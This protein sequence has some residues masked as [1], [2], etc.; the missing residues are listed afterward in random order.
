MHPLDCYQLT[1]EGR[2]LDFFSSDTL[3]RKTRHKLNNAPKSIKPNFSYKNI[4]ALSRKSNR[5]VDKRVFFF[6]GDLKVKSWLLRC[7]DT[8]EQNYRRR[9]SPIKTITTHRILHQITPNHTLLSIKRGCF[10][11]NRSLL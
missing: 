2:H 7:L 1:R 8:D 11:A 5:F 3:F 6:F 10:L 4:L 9:L